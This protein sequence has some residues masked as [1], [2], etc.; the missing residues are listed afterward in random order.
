[1][2]QIKT[3]AKALEKKLDVK[4]PF[5]IEKNDDWKYYESLT[6]FYKNE[7]YSIYLI[8]TICGKNVIEISQTTDNPQPFIEMIKE[9]EPEAE[10]IYSEISTLITYITKTI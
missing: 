2:K 4:D 8:C 10:I 3:I 9:I 7:Y 1:M 5:I 6:G